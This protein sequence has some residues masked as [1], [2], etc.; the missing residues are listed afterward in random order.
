MLN[1]HSYGI[2]ARIPAEITFAKW[3]EE[4]SKL[5]GKEAVSERLFRDKKGQILT[6][7]LAVYFDLRR[8]DLN[9]IP[10]ICEVGGI[11]VKIQHKALMQCRTCQ[12]KGHLADQCLRNRQE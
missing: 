1:T 2:T 11:K 3:R 12:G 6:N 7:K 8:Y 10:E 4:L 9:T 5:I